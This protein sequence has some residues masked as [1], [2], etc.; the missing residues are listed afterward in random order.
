MPSKYEQREEETWDPEDINYNTFRWITSNA[1]FAIGPS[2]VNPYTGQ[3]LDADILFDAD[4]IQSWQGDI[5]S[6]NPH[7]A[8][9]QA[10][11]ALLGGA[12]PDQEGTL[13]RMM[14]R[15][16]GGECMLGSTMAAELLLGATV[17]QQ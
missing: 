8:V 17:L 12:S 5:E 4:F 14:N 16:D 1:G 15:R 7:S 10:T 2:H 9:N 3:I 11:D 6:S 13:R